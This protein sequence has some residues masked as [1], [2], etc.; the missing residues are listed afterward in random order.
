MV[1]TYAKLTPTLK[2]P[3][4]TAPREISIPILSS[5]VLTALS[6]C[7]FPA[8]RDPLSV[9]VYRDGEIVR[10]LPVTLYYDV[11]KIQGG[12]DG[13]PAGLVVYSVGY[14]A[15]TPSA[16]S[17]A[18][19]LAERGY[20]VAVPHHNDL[21]AV[22]LCVPDFSGADEAT[23]NGPP[24]FASGQ[25]HGGPYGEKLFSEEQLEEFF[26]YRY[27]DLAA[28]VD[29]LVGTDEYPFGSLSNRPV[30]LVGYSL[31]GWNALNVAGAGSLYPELQRDVSAVICQNTFVGELSEERLQNVACPVFYLAGTEDAL[32]P[33]IRRLYDWRPDNSR[34]V[35]ILGADH[36]IFAADL[37]SSPVLSAMYPGT[38]D[39]AKIATAGKAN[40][41]TVDF[42][43]ALTTTNRVPRIENLASYSPDLFAIVR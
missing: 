3:T 11:D 7:F 2:L 22:C 1:S 5:L 20:V 29:E 36:Y 24:S 18:N 25:A 9:P 43:T 38:C 35:E 40:E 21:L 32:Y 30:F 12:K 4:M 8:D 16:Q 26:Y 15:C 17:L 28:T 39:D 31:G 41:L 19:M 14:S 13:Q 10:T 6:G 27:A 42:I 37:C 23:G 33:N 34:M